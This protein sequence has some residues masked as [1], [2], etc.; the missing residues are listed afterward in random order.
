MV[1]D[2]KF[3]QFGGRTH[4]GKITRMLKRTVSGIRK[5]ELIFFVHRICSLSTPCM[6]SFSRKDLRTIA[7][8][9]AM[10]PLST[11]V[12]VMS[13]IMSAQAQSHGPD[14]GPDVRRRTKKTEDECDCIIRK[15]NFLHSCRSK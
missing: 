11:T 2:E 4:T 1:K 12:S 10:F 14:H 9:P 15:H 13:E 7:L 5:C 6:Y 8:H 3:F